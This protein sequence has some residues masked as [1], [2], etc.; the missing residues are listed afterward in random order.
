MQIPEEPVVFS[1]AASALAGPNDA[2]AYSDAMSKLDWEVELGI[3]IGKRAFDIDEAAALDYVLGYTVVNDVSERV[4]QLERGGQWMK[5][6]SYP[7]FCPAGPW[8]VTREEVPDPQA[9]RLWLEVNGE[10]RQD[11][12]TATM[13]FSVA[14]I[15]SYLRQF[16]RLE[17]G[18][19]ICTG[20][21]PG[22]GA[23]MTPPV[24]LVP[25]DTV[26]LGIEGLGEQSQRIGR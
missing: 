5:G 17:P 11:G 26:R 15:V 8:L 12:R 1:K 2:I 7:G 25:G 6:K 24:F 22:V 3:I 16:A 13:I 18:D 9:L 4:W 20:T 21:P 10:R 19:L 14:R 23:G